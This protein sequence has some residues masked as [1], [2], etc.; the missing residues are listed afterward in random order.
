MKEMPG[1][2][3]SSIG[4]HRESELRSGASLGFVFMSPDTPPPP[5]FLI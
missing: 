5:R 1:K 2:T 4:G 3:I